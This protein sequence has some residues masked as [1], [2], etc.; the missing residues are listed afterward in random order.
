MY[1]TDASVMNITGMTNNEDADSPVNS[2]NNDL[3]ADKI[4]NYEE[5]QNDFGNQNI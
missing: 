2:M 5:D 4:M 3:F 1:E